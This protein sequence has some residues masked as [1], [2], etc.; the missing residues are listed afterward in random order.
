MHNGALAGYPLKSMRIRLLDGAIHPT[1]SHALDFEHAAVIG[2]KNVAAQAAPR[3]LEP[4]MKVSVTLPEEYTGAV[5]GDLNRRRG[6]I[7]QIATETQVQTINA[8]VPLS[9]LFGYIT[10]L[11]TLT[12]GRATASLTFEQYQAVPGNISQ[13]V[14]AK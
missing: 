11:R 3:L 4:W 2:F 1:D 14:L 12:S 8:M 13:Q 5:T 6:L 7:K 10:A 9:E